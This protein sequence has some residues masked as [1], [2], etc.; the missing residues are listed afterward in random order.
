MKIVQG[1]VE[2]ASG[3]TNMS[4]YLAVGVWHHWLERRDFEFVER[5]WPTV[6]KGLDFVTG[7]QLPFGGICWSQ[8]WDENGPAKIN[9]EALLAGSSSIYQYSLTSLCSP[10]T[11]TTRSWVVPCVAKQALS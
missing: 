1:E 7:M 3:E 2:D 11:G 10:W 4:A 5:M 8:E 6:R 9:R